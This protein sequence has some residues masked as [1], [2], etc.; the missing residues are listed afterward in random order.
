[1]SGL[2]EM[3]GNKQPAITE[4]EETKPARKTASVPPWRLNGNR[5]AIISEF[6]SVAVQ[7]QHSIHGGH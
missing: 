6:R 7:R 3:K 2:R 1:M 4:L 5:K